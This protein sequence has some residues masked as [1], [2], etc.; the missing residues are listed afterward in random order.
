MATTTKTKETKTLAQALVWSAA[1]HWETR[2]V[3]V[4]FSLADLKAYCR[5]HFKEITLIRVDHQIFSDPDV[6]GGD[7]LMWLAK[8]Q[9]LE[10]GRWTKH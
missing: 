3:G 9:V 7:W 2:D 6:K 8:S 1:G 4:R 5:E 10:Q